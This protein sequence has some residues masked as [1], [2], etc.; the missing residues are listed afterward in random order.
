[1]LFG[2]SRS[3]DESVLVW[4]AALILWGPG[5]SSSLHRHHCVQLLLA[6]RGDLRIREA[7]RRRW[8]ACGAAVV[9]PDAPH[10]VRAPRAVVL[11]GCFDPESE[12]GAALLERALRLTA[13][14]ASKPSAI[15]H[16]PDSRVRQWRKAL[17]DPASLDAH[18]VERWLRDSLL[19]SRNH[20]RRLHPGVRRVLRALRE[21]I[22]DYDEASLE[23][24]AKLGR[25]S[26]SRLM[27]VFTRSVGVPLRPYVRWLRL[28]RAAA[29]LT[30]GSSVTDA[31]HAAGFADAAHLT[32]TFREMFGATPSAIAARARRARELRI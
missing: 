20:Q 22:A 13:T 24:L 32:R 12:L 2:A 16:M 18:R 9:L 8:I 1:M 3:P 23:E 21:R 4:P 19:E 5:E 10:E 30:T 25:L 6:L 14:P 15:M 28:Q 7:A 27:H 17:G 11:I 26:S 31:A 29:E